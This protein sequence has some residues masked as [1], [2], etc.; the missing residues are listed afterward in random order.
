MSEEVVKPRIRG[1]I[2][3]NAHP[4]GCRQ[5][6]IRQIETTQAYGTSPAGFNMLV[7]GAS[8]GYGLSSRIAGAFG[9]GAKTLG[10]FFERP[11]DDRH[12]ATAGYYNAV[13]FHQEART[14]GL[15]AKSLN[16]DAFSDEI[17]A[18]TIDLIRREMGRIDVVVYSLASPRRTHP[19]TGLTH[20]SV[21]KPIGKTY[22]NKSIDLNTGNVIDVMIEPAVEAEIADTVAVMGGE[23]VALWVD[24]LLDAGLLAEG[25]RVVAFSYIGPAVTHPVYRS[26]TIGKAKEHLEATIRVLNTRLRHAV[27]GNAYVSINKAVATHASVAI[28]VVPLY[29]SMLYPIMR[30]HGIHEDPIHQMNRLFRDHLAPDRTPALDDKGRIRLD[31]RELRHDVQTEIERRWERVN[32][33]NLCE[34]SDFVGFQREFRQLFGFEVDGVDYEAP[35]EINRSLEDQG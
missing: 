6:V 19:K 35:T 10:I 5:N 31:D 14:Q 34:L 7:I 23:D 11:P 21:L 20:T 18:E 30:V 28:P 12:T 1:F 29:L 15:Y 27:G 22:T 2:C 3:T 9:Y 17:K 33:E 4:E 26:G 8:T 25:T 24:V 13:A 32:T 16:G